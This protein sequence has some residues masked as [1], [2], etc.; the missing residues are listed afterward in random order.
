MKTDQL[1]EAVIVNEISKAEQ[2]KA[3]IQ[4]E[5]EVRLRNFMIAVQSAEKSFNCVL[6]CRTIIQGEKII[7]QI[8]PFAND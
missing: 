7:Q 5:K 2:L 4:A 6:A 3:E 8:V 1:D